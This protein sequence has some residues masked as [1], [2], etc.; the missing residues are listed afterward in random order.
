MSE[1]SVYN[2]RIT[3]CDYCHREAVTEENDHRVVPPGWRLCWWSM[4]VGDHD[5]GSPYPQAMSFCSLNCAKGGALAY[6]DEI[7]GAKS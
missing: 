3:T 4:T 5:T 6:L 7:L 2:A 1:R